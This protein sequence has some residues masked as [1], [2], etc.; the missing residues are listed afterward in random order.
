M[1]ELDK[2]F[3]RAELL[4][5][6]AWWDRAESRLARRVRLHGV[7]ALAEYE[8]ERLGLSRDAWR[9]AMA[10]RPELLN[11][12]N[13]PWES[14]GRVPTGVVPVFGTASDNGCR[15]RDLSRVGGDRA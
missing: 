1:I 7:I 12:Y 11:E 14:S 5:F 4:A 2:H 10:V 8:L 3:R 13:D 9:E 15:G 6:Q